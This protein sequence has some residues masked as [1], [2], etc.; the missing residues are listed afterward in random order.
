M[1]R[2]W[3]HNGEAM[4]RL[5]VSYGEAMGIGRLWGGYGEVMGRLWGSYGEQTYACIIKNVRK[6]WGGYVW[7]GNEEA[8]ERLWR[9]H[10]EAMG[11]R[12]K[13]MG[14]LWGWPWGIYRGNTCLHK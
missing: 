6:L 4:E 14:R 2:L 13:A 12:K 3:G 9:G 8:M 1:G 10:G 11:I 5:R 7:G